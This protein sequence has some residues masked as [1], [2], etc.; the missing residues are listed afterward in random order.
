MPTTT[1]T[2][3]PS[4][5]PWASLP[6]TSAS[7]RRRSASRYDVGVCDDVPIDRRPSAPSVAVDDH[8]QMKERARRRA[9]TLRVVGVDGTGG[10]HDAV[11]AGGFRRPD[12]GARI[13]GVGHAGQDHNERCI[14]RQRTRRHRHH[15][16]NAARR[17]HVG[18]GI[19]HAVVDVANGH[20][21]GKID[22]CRRTAE[23]LLDREAGRHGLGEKGRAFHHEGTLAVACTATPQE[24]P[25]PLN[26]G[27]SENERPG[28]A[29]TSSRALRAALTSVP[30]AAASLTA[31]SAR[32][33]RSTS[34]PAALRPAMKRL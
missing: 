33:L 22:R 8:R 19:H 7:G 24:A 23:D 9:N 29:T 5:I 15:G 28:Q 25:Q 13:A 20:P 32:T 10:Q 34:M 18:D 30:K 31:S 17:F 4:G 12:D 26:S 11:G 14:R 3:M 21:G 16:K 2:S 27:I 1:S 6:N